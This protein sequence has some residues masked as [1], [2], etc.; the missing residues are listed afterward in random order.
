MIRPHDSSDMLPFNNHLISDP[1]HD[2]HEGVVGNVFYSSVCYSKILIDDFTSSFI[3]NG[4]IHYATLLN[5]SK[6]LKSIL[7]EKI[8]SVD[9]NI[10][11]IKKEKIT[12]MDFKNLIFLVRLSK[13]ETIKLK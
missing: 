10:V 5:Y 8:F 1:F 12:I 7:N 3:F 13:T 6:A 4:V 11:D 2:L 9:L